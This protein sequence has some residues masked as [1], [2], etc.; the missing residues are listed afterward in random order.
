M[1]AT[2]AEVEKG[3]KEKA[4]V[5]KAEKEWKRVLLARIV[6]GVDV[7]AEAQRTGLSADLITEALQPGGMYLPGQPKQRTRNG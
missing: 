1:K 7:N 2:M 3:E 6:R 4:E 5:E